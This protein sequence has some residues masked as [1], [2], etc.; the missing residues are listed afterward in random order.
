MCKNLL[1]YSYIS[2][3]PGKLLSYHSH[4]KRMIL[5]FAMIL[6]VSCGGRPGADLSTVMRARPDQMRLVFDYAGV[7]TDVTETTTRYLRNI[8]ERYG[9]EILVAALPSLEGRYTVNEAAVAMFSNWG[10]GRAFG[11]RGILLLLVDD[12]KQVR[13]EIGFELEDVFTDLFSGHSQEKQLRPHYSAGHLDTGLIALL[14]ELE[15]RARVKFSGEYDRA[16]IADMDARYLSQGGG[17][18]YQLDAHASKA[19][20]SRA[21]NTDYPAGDTPREAWK[22]LIRKWRDRQRDPW[23]GI[24][25]PTARLAYRDYTGMPDSSFDENVRKYAEKEFTVLRDGDHAVIYFGKKAGWD[26]SPFLLC[27]TTEGWQF[28]LVHQ[29]RYIRMGTAPDWGVEFSE[30][31]Y[32]GMLMD[33]FGFSGQDIPLTGEDRYTTDRDTERAEAILAREAQRAADPDNFE[34]VMALGRLYALTAMGRKA[35]PLLKAA[36]RLKPEDPRPDKYLAV[37]HV[38]AHYQYD[39]ALKSI[40]AYIEKRPEDLFGRNFRGFILY[41]KGRDADAAQAFEAALSLEP[42][43]CYAHYYLAYVYARRYNDASSL[44]P[45]RNGFLKRHREHVAKTRSFRDT[46]PLRVEKLERW[47]KAKG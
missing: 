33:C 36:K 27:Q 34:P 19:V 3:A 2:L 28:D 17:A 41:R 39:A 12:E 31:P 45:R 35:I 10:V 15:A 22:T 46:H 29:R 11:G 8:R 5:A 23:L 38:D 21:V 42:D 1:I 26:N 25:T 40:E 20:F 16:A 32:M 6:V 43:N 18:K 37:A 47:L 24:L 30:H 14:E 9:I 7:M 13:L 44:D 4:M